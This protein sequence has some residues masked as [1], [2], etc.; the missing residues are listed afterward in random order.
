M[1]VCI[2][3]VV[4]RLE[5]RLVFWP[6]LGGGAT[7]VRLHEEERQACVAMFVSTAMGR[8]C[9][10]LSVPDA[11][12]AQVRRKSALAQEWQAV[13]KEKKQPK[14]A[15]CAKPVYARAGAFLCSQTVESQREAM[16]PA[17]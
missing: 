16:R 9:R 12:P 13:V 14:S 1:R 7:P 11:P 17:W 10:E 15:G 3:V 4:H 2:D 6:A 8:P 5:R